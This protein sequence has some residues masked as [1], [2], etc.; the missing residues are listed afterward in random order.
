MS[1]IDGVS[2]K[3]GDKTVPLKPLIDALHEED[4][5]QIYERLAEMDQEIMDRILRGPLKEPDAVFPQLWTIKGKQLRNGK[6]EFDINSE[7]L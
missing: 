3:F 5:S 7:Q 4:R 1:L 2:V 6:L